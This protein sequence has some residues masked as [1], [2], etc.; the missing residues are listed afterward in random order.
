MAPTFNLYLTLQLRYLNIAC[1]HLTKL[2]KEE[3]I[4]SKSIYY[5]EER[6]E[7]FNWLYSG[8]FR[9]IEPFQLRHKAVEATI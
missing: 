3:R 7:A 1:I 6:S 5:I 9:W 2:T 4:V 8:E